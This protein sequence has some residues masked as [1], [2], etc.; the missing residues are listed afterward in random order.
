MPEPLAG[1]SPLLSAGYALLWW[2]VLAAL[3]AVAWTGLQRPLRSWRDGGWS[4]AR[5][6]GLLAPA[7]AVW[8]A[9]HL[10]PAF[11]QALVFGSVPV[12]GAA[13]WW[14]RVRA[15]PGAPPSRA[16][17]RAL[18]MA[19]ARVLLTAELR[20]AVPYASYLL[21]RGFNA[22]IVGLEK[23]MD[24]AFMNSALHSP[25]MPPPD[26]W[27]GGHTI[28]Y[29]YFGHYLAAFVC[30]LT[31][32]PPQFGYNL[33]L[34]T[35][36]AGTFQLA[37]AFLA[38]LTAACAPK[39]GSLAP[40]AAAFWTTMGGNLHAFLYG[41]LKPVLVAWGIAGAPMQP[42]LIS[43]P[44]RFVGYDPPGPDKLITEFP[45]YA[46]YVGD[47]HAHLTNLPNVLLFLCALL[48]WLRARARQEAGAARAWL[49]GASALLGLFVAANTWD[50][51]MY[52]GV[53]GLLLA[54]PL[55]MGA[56]TRQDVFRSVL[57]DA[58]IATGA[59]AFVAGW[60]LAGFQPP[61]DGVG[62]T[63]SHTPLWQWLILYGE[64]AAL[65]AAGALLLGQRRATSEGTLFLV[66]AACGAG[67]AVVPEVIYLR[68]IYGSEFYR[69][70]TAF[71]FGFQAFLLL[72]LSACVGI[73]MMVDH[74]VRA[75]WRPALAVL[76]LEALLLPPLSFSWFVASGALGASWHRQWSLDGWRH[77]ARHDGD[78]QLI[79]WLLAQRQPGDVLIE[80]VGESYSFAARLSTYS[81]VP[82]VLG[83]PVHE[84]L[85]R[86]RDPAVAAR[87]GAIT[88][89]YSTRD[90]EEVRRIA[91]TY[92]A[93]W[94]VVG[95]T[96]RSLHPMLDEA[97]LRSAGQ[98][99]FETG[100]S[101]IVQM[102]SGWS[103]SRS[104]AAKP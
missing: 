4:V 23:F 37:W 34:A 102:A 53:L 75:R 92:G 103:T 69:G 74:A 82:A 84:T 15:A 66:I 64:P 85:W 90:P 10:G 19:E 2:A 25:A 7:V 3:G 39:A 12:L 101:F 20:F 68:D 35:V 31:G 36:F 87:Q 44:T 49:A 8:I 13:A 54:L 61:G 28:N 57:L 32:R 38:E 9:A 95:G 47:L 22:D 5:Q 42:F 62:L 29:Y 78:A 18:L 93:R 45:A 41:I 70:N 27:F 14:L 50:A 77:L 59:A 94:V 21:M 88:A 48:A 55:L 81:A 26:P 17:A 63:H 65:A 51:G 43:D 96:E 79:R 1:A 24:F 72:T 100:Q 104:Q 97:A 60:F 83:W 86:R 73:A 56:G 40:A 46:F 30:K 80:A 76:M 98:V 89:L 91:G 71:K 6:A 16:Q 67:F 99:V 52:A 33:M 11:T 58:A